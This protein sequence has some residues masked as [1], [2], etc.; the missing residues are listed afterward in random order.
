M[1]INHV[2]EGS[3]RQGKEH[4]YCRIIRP[5]EEGTCELGFMVD[6]IV[7][8]KH[9]SFNLDGSLNDAEGLYEGKKMAY[10]MKIENFVQK[11]K[12]H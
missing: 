4:G 11:I 3:L 5:I 7:S 12:D 8:G 2:F 9:C 10:K 6:G 1:R